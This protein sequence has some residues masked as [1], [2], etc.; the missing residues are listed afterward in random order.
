MATGSRMVRVCVC[1]DYAQGYL[2]LH[3]P[4]LYCPVRH[5]RP[6]ICRIAAIGQ[7]LSPKRKGKLVLTELRSLARAGGW[8]QASKLGTH[9]VRRGAARAILEAGGSFSQLLR[10]GQWR[11][12]AYKL[13]LDMGREETTAVSSLLTDASDDE[14]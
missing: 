9:S 12:L 3:A 1:E 13:C 8:A 2:E 4:Q 6:A 10:A 7:P 11:S 14:V 5:L